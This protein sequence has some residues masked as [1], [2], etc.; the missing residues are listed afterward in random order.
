MP[1]LGDSSSGAFDSLRGSKLDFNHIEDEVLPSLIPGLVLCLYGS[2]LTLLD[3]EGC[4]IL[5]PRFAFAL[6]KGFV[7]LRVLRPPL[8]ALVYRLC[9]IRSAYQACCK[10][11]FVGHSF[12]IFP[13]FKV[14]PAHL[15]GFGWC[16]L[17]LV[18]TSVLF[19]LS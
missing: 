14:R 13:A 2:L 3:S 8:V 5:I 19:A 18:L 9:C 10:S 4:S 17:G 6:K 11:S 16:A 15:L 1:G 12:L 7:N